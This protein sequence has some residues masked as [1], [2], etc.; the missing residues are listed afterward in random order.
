MLALM[1]GLAG[2]SKLGLLSKSP[3]AKTGVVGKTPDFRKAF[4]KDQVAKSKKMLGKTDE[5]RKT[6]TSPRKINMK[7]KFVDAKGNVTVGGK[8]LGVGNVKSKFASSEGVFKAGKKVADLNPKS[9]V[10]M[11][12]GAL[13]VGNKTF[14]TKADFKAAMQKKRA[15]GNP[16][17]KNIL[18]KFVL[19]P[20]SQLK[21]GKM[22]K[23]RGGGMAR[24]KP[25][26]MY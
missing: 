20:K 16:G 18:N 9:I 4:A 11:P 26:K 6:F 25:T 5:F 3:F 12:D 1:V 14:N 13:K 21:T 24:T 15:E 17:F 23:A 19:G 10:K 7:S 2:A 22:V 8:N